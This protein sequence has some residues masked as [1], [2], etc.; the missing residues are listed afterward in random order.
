[1]A[2]GRSP[3]LPHQSIRPITTL[4]GGV[5]AAKFLRGL[6]RVADAAA[7]ARPPG[8]DPFDVRDVV[9]WLEPVVQFD[10]LAL[11]REIES[12]AP[13]ASGSRETRGRRA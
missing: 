5:G 4:A 6:V 11:R 12:A 1:M 2:R 13:R 8:A 3:R 10:P 7:K 9:D